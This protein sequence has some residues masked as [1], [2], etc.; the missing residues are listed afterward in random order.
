MVEI[1]FKNGEKLGNKTGFSSYIVFVNKIAIPF[2]H[3]STFHPSNPHFFLI[4]VVETIN[5]FKLQSK[6]IQIMYKIQNLNKI[7]EEGLK[8]FPSDQYQIDS[9]IADPDAI[10]LRSFDMLNMELPASLLAIARAGAGFNNIPV[11]RCTEKGIVVFNTPGANANG[12]KE[13]VIAGML[14]TSRGIG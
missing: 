10:I 12:V 1:C 14:L 6:I 5:F 7:D 13:L 9:K 11:D 4:F 3:L 2:S 8:I